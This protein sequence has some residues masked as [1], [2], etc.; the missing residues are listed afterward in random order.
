MR[1]AIVDDEYNEL[2]HLEEALKRC[3]PAFGY[4][5]ETSDRYENA[6][7]FLT[8][9]HPGKY[10]IIFLDIYMDGMP[11]I[12]AARIIRGSDSGVRLVF[13][14][15]SNEFA[16]ESY[17]VAAHYYLLKPFSENDIMKMLQ[18]LNLEDFSYNRFITLPDG[19]NVILRNIIY[20]EYYNHTVTI[21]NKKG[22]DIRTRISQTSFE[23][24]ISEFSYLRCCSKGII[25]NFHEV[26]KQHE[27]TFLMSN[28]KTI[29][30]SRRKIKE[31][32]DAYTDFRFERIRKEMTS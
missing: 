2:N 22:G 21:Y 14:T 17:E 23:N 25:V 11:G 19:Q 24:L 12:D 32:N 4:S 1:L 13:C 29:Y 5:V 30:I 3:L 26:I 8:A 6:E 28:Q 10:D 18:R 15:S 27:N 7:Q 16:S 20:T 9:W 31:I